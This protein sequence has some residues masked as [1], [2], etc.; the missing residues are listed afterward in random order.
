MTLKPH[1]R[2]GVGSQVDLQVARNATNFTSAKVSGKGQPKCRD[3]L[4]RS[5]FGLLPLPAAKLSQ[6]EP[7]FISLSSS[8]WASLPF[9]FLGILIFFNGDGKGMRCVPLKRIG[10]HSSGTLGCITPR[11]VDMAQYGQMN[12]FPQ[13]SR[14]RDAQLATS[15]KHKFINVGNGWSAN[16]QLGWQHF[17]P[18]II[19]GIRYQPSKN[20]NQI[21][22][23]ESNPLHSKALLLR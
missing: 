9:N 20:W 12:R 11:K 2:L 16:K 15:S 22:C 6:E 14:T 5:L 7:L 23:L 1:G 3:H 8:R 10:L 13:G 18:E 21:C 4:N 19:S 17:W